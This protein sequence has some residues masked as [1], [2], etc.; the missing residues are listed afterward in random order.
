MTMTMDK[1]DQ[2]GQGRTLSRS[3]VM[4]TTQKSKPNERKK[5]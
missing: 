5:F 2:F 4:L 1:E 3:T